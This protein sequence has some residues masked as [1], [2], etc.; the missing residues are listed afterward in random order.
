MFPPGLEFIEAFFGCIYAGVLA[1]PMSPP[2]RRDLSSRISAIVED[3]QAMV[4]LTNAWGSDV[5]LGTGGTDFLEQLQWVPVDTVGDEGADDWEPPEVDADDLAF[6]QY[7]SGST[8]QPRGVMVSHGNL[9][10][11]LEVIRT[12]FGVKQGHP[13]EPA[14]LGVSWLPMY[15]DMGLIGGIL[16]SLWAGGTTILMSPSSFLQRPER[17]LRAI[18]DHGA[19][20]SGAPNFAYDL[21]VRKIDDERLE[22]L[23]LSNWRVAFCGAEPI[24]PET[25]ERFVERFAPCGFREDAL[26][27]CYGLAEATLLVT[28]SQGPSGAT[29]R[30]FRRSKLQADGVAERD[31]GVDSD[32]RKL[33]GCGTTMLGQTLAIVNPLTRASCGEDTVGEIWVR[34]ASVTA[35]YWKTGSSSD[36]FEA[37]VSDTGEGPFLRTG[38]LGFVHGGE[39]FVT[40]RL[41]ELLIIR[42]RNLD[43]ADIEFTAQSAHPALLP[44]SGAAFSQEVDGEERLILVNELDRAHRKA[45][46]D[47]IFRTVRGRV[48]E[49]HGVT[50]HA[51]VLIRPTTLPRTTSGKVQRSVAAEQYA[52][53]QLKVIAEWSKQDSTRSPGKP[54]IRHDRT[55]TRSP[56]VDRLAEQIERRI[57]EWLRDRVGVPT[58]ELSRDRPFAEHGVDSMAAVELSCELEDWLK[59]KLSPMT[60][61][62]YPTPAAIARYLAAESSSSQDECVSA[63]EPGTQQEDAGLAHLLKSLDDLSES[64]ALELIDEVNTSH[65]AV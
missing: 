53:R 52:S 44:D 20:V 5:L 55:T 59:I 15:H 37:Y 49:Q 60:A 31:H 41:K 36:H 21:C 57:L 33:V 26:Y 2:K 64:Q 62:Q 51:L 11:N 32:A 47:E 40:G 48:T 14:G 4:G 25:M 43:P 46:F 27:P 9:I 30:R 24:R 28:G 63:P 65:D 7:T 10:H 58:E 12:G 38:D 3:C 16:A 6:L 50:P 22:S 13:H 17:W 8:D 1:V 18:S 42:G 54:R 56:K 39:L 29:I 34:G 23:D 35:G 19:C 61:W 45:S